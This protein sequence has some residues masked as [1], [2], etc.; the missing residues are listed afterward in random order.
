MFF[1]VFLIPP[2]PPVLPVMLSSKLLPE[3]EMEDNSKREQL[4]HG[5]QNLQ[6]LSQIDKLKVYYN[7]LVVIVILYFFL[8]A[9]S[10]I[11]IFLYVYR[12]ELI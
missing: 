10:L 8:L 5:M 9:L 4:L 11:F 7:Q 2:P 6:L 12:P 1:F 3:M